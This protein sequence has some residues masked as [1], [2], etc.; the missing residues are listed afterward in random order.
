[1]NEENKVA[2]ILKI[3]AIVAMVLCVIGSLVLANKEEKKLVSEGTLYT[4]PKYET[5]KG[6]DSVD[7]LANVIVCGMF[8]F[9]FYA[10]GESIQ[11]QDD[12]RKLLM[13]LVNKE[14]EKEFEQ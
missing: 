12:N 3:G 5:E 7:F 13:K 8:C 6:F 4:E 10:F 11:I 9:L 14:P 1:M 2:K